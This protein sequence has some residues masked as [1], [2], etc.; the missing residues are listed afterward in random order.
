[1]NNYYWTRWF[2]CIKAHQ[3]TFWHIKE[4]HSIKNLRIFAVQKLKWYSVHRALN[5]KSW[6]NTPGS[7]PKVTF[8]LIILHVYSFDL[9]KEYINK[10]FRCN[11]FVHTLSSS[12]CQVIYSVKILAMFLIF[13]NQHRIVASYMDKR[14]AVMKYCSLSILAFEHTLDEQPNFYSVSLLS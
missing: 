1:M 12:T 13:Y 9:Y 3:I 4:A 5:F 10:I 2:S 14:E 11:L 8:L 6:F 7:L